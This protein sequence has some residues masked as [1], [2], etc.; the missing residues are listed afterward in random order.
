MIVFLLGFRSRPCSIPISD[1]LVDG[2]AA[3]HGR[4]VPRARSVMWRQTQ[5]GHSIQFT[6][7]FQLSALYRSLDAN[8][9]VQR[10]VSERPTGSVKMRKI[11][12]SRKTDTVSMTSFRATITIMTSIMMIII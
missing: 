12:F 7:L 8:E 3:S 5:A 4:A 9:S 1:V 10:V 2:G 6:L 11:R